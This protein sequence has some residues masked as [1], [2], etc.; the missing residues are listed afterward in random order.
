MPSYWKE[1]SG[2]YVWYTLWCIPHMM[3][4]YN[5]VYPMLMYTWH[6]I[7]MMLLMMRYPC[8]HYTMMLLLILHDDWWYLVHHDDAL[9]L[10][11][12]V[13]M[14]HTWWSMRAVVTMMYMSRW[15]AEWLAEID[16]TFNQQ[17]W[18]AEVDKQRMIT[19]GWSTEMVEQQ[20]DD[21]QRLASSLQV[22]SCTWGLDTSTFS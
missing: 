1:Y 5:E 20:I 15:P 18:W 4:I 6:Y 22:E 8:W 13:L 2:K 11:K 3:M 17:H 10:M 19:R 12:D 7:L 21:N 9:Y 14:M 16:Q